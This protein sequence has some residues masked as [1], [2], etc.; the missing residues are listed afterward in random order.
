[1]DMTTTDTQQHSTVAVCEA[2]GVPRS[3][4]HLFTRWA[5]GPLTSRTVDALYAYVDVM[6]AD[7]CRRPAD[8][9][10]SKLIELKADGQDL[11]V[12]DIRS[13]VAALAIGA[14]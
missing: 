4:W 8:D 14:G 9:L 13:F 10:V 3:D 2:L 11:T 12:D 5:A 1:M 6:I 7:R